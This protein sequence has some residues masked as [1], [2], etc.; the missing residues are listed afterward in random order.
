[1]IKKLLKFYQKIRLGEKFKHQYSCHPDF[2]IS[3][4]NN[5]CDVFFKSKLI[6]SIHLAHKLEKK[7]RNSCFIIATGPSLGDFDLNKI[8]NFDTISLNCAIKKFNSSQLKPTHC[9]IVDKKIF[10]NEWECVESSVLSGANCYFSFVGLSKICEKNPSLLT[11]GNIYLIESI[12]RKFG[13]PF[14][15]VDDFLSAF[16]TDPEV[17]LDQNLYKYCRS[18]GFSLNLAKGLFSGKTV[19]TWATQ[20]SFNLGYKNIFLVGM[21][22]GG[23]GKSHFYVEENN[24]IPDFLKDYEPH[25]RACFELA[26]KVCEKNNWGIFNLS[27]KSTLP[28]KI[29][30][31]ISLDEALKIAFNDTLIKTK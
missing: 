11:H 4:K 25:I 21:D 24:G 31:K 30:K 16:A 27:M 1:M 26:K 20:L 10:D 2:Y 15:S 7:F 23:T 5:R 6:A 29:V 22:L 3:K 8:K 9:I 13:H 18:I 17:W 19:A 28:D 14:P 12:S